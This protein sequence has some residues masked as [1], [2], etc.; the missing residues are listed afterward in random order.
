MCKESVQRNVWAFTIGL[1]G[2]RLPL[3]PQGQ[4]DPSLEV[5]ILGVEVPLAPQQFQ[6]PFQKHPPL[7]GVFR[8]ATIKLG[9][10]AGG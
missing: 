10:G 8:P 1:G 5:K 3:L 6:H 4:V 7:R 9:S 2:H